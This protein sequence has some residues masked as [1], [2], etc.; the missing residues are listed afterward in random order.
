[1][2]TA[3]DAAGFARLVHYPVRVFDARGQRK[4][5]R[6]SY[7]VQKYS[8]I[9]TPDVRNAVLAQSAD[10]LFGNYQGMMIG[11]GQVW[12]QPEANGDMR[13]VTINTAAR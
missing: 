4:I 10:C 12:F 2:V 8:S 3:D 13:I 5:A 11:N 6:R 9:V 1:M 7:L